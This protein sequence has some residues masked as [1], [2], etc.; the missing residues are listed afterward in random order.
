MKR[1]PEMPT[2]SKAARRMI[3]RGERTSTRS[4]RIR[5]KNMMRSLRNG[6]AQMLA[7]PISD[8]GKPIRPVVSYRN[9]APKSGFNPRLCS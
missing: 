5:A 6:D 3:Y 8:T 9:T 7:R 4:S 2:I 1:N